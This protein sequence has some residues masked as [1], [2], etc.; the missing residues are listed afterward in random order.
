LDANRSA[1]AMNLQKALHDFTEALN[2]ANRAPAR[3]ARL[4]AA[5]RILVLQGIEALEIEASGYP[6]LATVITAAAAA[7]PTPGR[8]SFAVLIVHALAVKGLVPAA[9]VGDVCALVETA[10]RG[11]LLRSGY[12]FAG[13]AYDK[14][15]ALE[16]L[17]TTIGQLLEPLEP[18]FPNWQGLYSG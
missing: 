7:P 13:T 4:R 6:T 11:V 8:R 18:T 9:S 1:M 16:Q 10:L 3:D 5:R 17:H 15:R 14:R 12:P 2:S